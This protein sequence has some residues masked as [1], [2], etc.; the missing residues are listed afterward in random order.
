MDGADDCASNPNETAPATS[1]VICVPY[2]GLRLTLG[3]VDPSIQEF[4]MVCP[5]VGIASSC[6]VL[7]CWVPTVP[8]LIYRSTVTLPVIVLVPVRTPTLAVAVAL[9]FN[10]IL[11]PVF[12]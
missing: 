4:L 10:V 5:V 8:V 7:W 1:P 3:P 9:D 6:H 12:K 11:S 2:P